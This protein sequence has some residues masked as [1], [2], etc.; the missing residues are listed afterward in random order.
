MASGSL[1]RR[2]LLA[3][4]AAAGV[5]GVMPALNGEA[6]RKKKKKKGGGKKDY[7]CSDFKTQKEAQKF[8]KRHG[9]PQ[10]DPYNLDGDGDGI[11]CE[12]LP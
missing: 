11:A 2:A 8:F 5:M 7:N 9:G 1:T 12:S 4:F 3:S 6:R 10:Q